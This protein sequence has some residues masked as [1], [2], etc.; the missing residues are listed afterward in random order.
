MRLPCGLSDQSVPGLCNATQATTNGSATAISSTLISLLVLVHNAFPPVRHYTRKFFQLSYY[1]PQ[2]NMYGQG[3]D[4]LFLVVYWIVVFTAVRAT[5][6]DYVFKPFAQ[7]A[8]VKTKKGR[9][10]FAE[11]AWLFVYPSVSWSLG[12]VRQPKDIFLGEK[13]VKC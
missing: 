4:D 7:W 5:V 11:Q 2:F 10:R 9:V 8:G 12:M 13:A 1:K 6:M 3:W